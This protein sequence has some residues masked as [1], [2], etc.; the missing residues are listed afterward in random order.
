MPSLSDDAYIHL[1]TLI[2]DVSFRA[3]R[4]RE[5]IALGRSLRTLDGS[6]QGFFI[7]SKGFAQNPATFAQ[8]RVSNQWRNIEENPMVE[9]E[10]YRA[11]SGIRFINRA[12][13]Q[14]GGGPADP[15]VLQWLDQ[16]LE[17]GGQI[18]GA[19]DAMRLQE[20]SDFSTRFDTHLRK[21]IGKQK[22]SVDSEA[23][24][25]FMIATILSTRL[26]S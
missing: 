21:V 19:I 11:A 3:G 25:L 1:K 7:D 4:L 8:V 2:A 6:F 26:D 23:E 9:L 22:A 17:L 10:G 18:R 24:Q 20:I 12:L 13:V 5:W 15:T 14:N 16:L